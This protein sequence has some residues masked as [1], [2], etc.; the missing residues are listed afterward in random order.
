MTVN[1]LKR[2]LRR[3]IDYVRRD[4]LWIQ[5]V[6]KVAT[7]QACRGILREVEPIM[8][9]NA[10]QLIQ[11]IQQYILGLDAE[12]RTCEEIDRNNPL[13]GIAEGR[14][15]LLMHQLNTCSRYQRQIA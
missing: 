9:L 5:S 10:R 15:K 1:A 12:M 6:E 7:Y 8:G 4:P 13:Y 14:R 3:Q 2:E 11:A